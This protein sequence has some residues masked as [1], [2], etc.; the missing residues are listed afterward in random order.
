MLPYF[1]IRAVTVGPVRVPVQPLL[2]SLGV[3]TAHALFLWR[4]RRWGLD[5][6]KASWLSLT[7]VAV[8]VT[9]AFLFRWAYLP[10]ALERD[11]WIWLKTTSGAASFG[12]IAGGLLGAALYGRLRGLSTLEYLDALASVF[13]AGWIFG[14]IGC[15]LIH[16]HPGLRSEH[17]LAVRYPDFPR[18]DLAVVEVLFLA[19][20]LIPLFGW[21]GRKKR[22]P[23]S[24]LGMFLLIYGVFRVWLDVLH[25]DPPR[26]FGWTVDQLA[27]GPMAL[28][29]ALLLTRTRVGRS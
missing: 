6:E 12:G 2:A 7:M 24:M 11:P 26:Y 9:C 25:V 15:S 27:Y 22:A 8:G 5:V 1:E 10:G 28:V 14:R 16:D 3:L 23:G 4:A 29:G 18:W 17:L 21:L 20:I 19:G 13:P